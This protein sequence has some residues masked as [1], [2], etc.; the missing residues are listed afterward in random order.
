[1]IRH[2]C[3]Y[4]AFLLLAGTLLL[5]T[6]SLQAQSE[7]SGNPQSAAAKSTAKTEKL[8]SL[9]VRI[10]GIEDFK[11]KLMIGLYDDPAKFPNDNGEARGGSVRV[12]GP[13]HSFTFKDVPYGSYAIAV[14]HDA[15]ENGEMDVNWLGM[16]KEGYAFSNN[17][18]AMFS[19]PDFKDARFVVNGDV[20]IKI[21]MTY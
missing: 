21:T 19:A 13:E 10:G 14:L 18:T 12:T 16:P 6:P 9:T 3:T 11:G 20:T 17:A 15:N 8:G 5:G 1:M 7:R 4:F 2:H